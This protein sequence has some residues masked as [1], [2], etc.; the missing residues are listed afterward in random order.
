[1]KNTL[2]AL[3]FLF[4][5]CSNNESIENKPA[6]VELQ[7]SIN[8]KIDS[9]EFSN[10]IA[11]IGAYYSCGL[12]IGVG[13]Y[14]KKSNVKSDLLKF[15]LTKDGQLQFLLYTDKRTYT[16]KDYCSADFI[17][18]ETIT[19]SN[20]E[21]IENVKLKFKFNGKVFKKKY[22]L[23][24]P[25]ETVQLDGQV[26]INLFEK[27]N[28]NTFINFINLNNDIKF[29]K[30]SKSENNGSISYLCNSFNGYN[31]SFE[32]LN[33]S[34]IDLPI[35]TY[36]FSTTS[37]NNKIK[38]KK[39]I[40]QPKNYSTIFLIPSDWK[41]YETQGSFTV[42]NKSIINGHTVAK[43]KLNFTASFNGIVEYDFINAPFETAI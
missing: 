31:I 22:N 39:Y 9:N 41:E 6:I 14:E 42:I 16:T 11:Y 19:I 18:A 3:L 13:V 12:D 38:F 4:L 35:G 24:Q 17:P 30:I 25:D 33:Q 15:M 8:L 32:N 29:Q 10:E 7:N 2:H 20:F 21:F 37:L 36:S 23:Q 40:S 27:S 1:M 5:S 43:L 28:C 26:N 34:I